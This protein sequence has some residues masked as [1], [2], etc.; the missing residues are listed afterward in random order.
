MNI[1]KKVF[2]IIWIP[3]A[4][5]VWIGLSLDT[6][7]SFMELSD[8]IGDADLQ[9]EKAAGIEVRAEKDAEIAR[10]ASAEKAA[11]KAAEKARADAL[12]APRIEELKGLKDS[13][14]FSKAVW[15]CRR[16]VARLL[17]KRMLYSPEYDEEFKV[18]YGSEYSSHKDWRTLFIYSEDVSFIRTLIGTLVPVD[19]ECQF[20][21]KPNRKGVLKANLRADNLIW[22]T[23]NGRTVH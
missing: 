14:Q 20:N 15:D 8:V 5:A 7:P 17:R 22:V 16:E 12:D 10:V 2:K 3:A 13:G 21:F 11:K 23:F 4:V 18:R 9:A 1:I 6:S 19:F